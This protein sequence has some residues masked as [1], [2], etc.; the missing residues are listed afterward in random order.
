VPI[1]FGGVRPARTGV[2]PKLGEHNHLLAKK[3]LET[4]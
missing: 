1:S 3:T 2:T 4:S